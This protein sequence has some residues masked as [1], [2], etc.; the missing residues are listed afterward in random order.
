MSNTLEVK[1][2]TCPE[3]AKEFSPKG[4]TI[5]EKKL[6][7]AEDRAIHGFMSQACKAF[8]K[9][10]EIQVLCYISKTEL[11]KYLKELST[12]ENFPQVNTL[13]IALDADTD[14]QSAIKS[15]IKSAFEKVPNTDLPIPK[16]PF[17][18]IE[19]EK[20]K[21]AFVLFPGPDAKGRFQT[22]S[23]E[24][25]YLALVSH[26]RLIKNCVEPFIECAQSN[27]ENGETVTHISKSKL[28]AYLAGKHHHV[29]INLSIMAQCRLWDWNDRRITPFK[30]IIEQ[31]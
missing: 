28:H 31:M 1:H 24:D 19:N 11:G 27:Q 2:V 16:E 5:Y 14:E 8:A 21:T 12:V 23:I 30:K 13:V 6:I 18:F 20:M 25:L 9:T 29:G 15:S 4:P 10:D 22:G 17:S 3:C 26:D 7:L